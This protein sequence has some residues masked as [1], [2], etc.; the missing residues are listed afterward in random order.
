MNGAPVLADRVCYTCCTP[1]HPGRCPSVQVPDNIYG[2]CGEAEIIEDRE[3]LIMVDH[4][5][6]FGE[7][8]LDLVDVLP[9]EAG[10]LK[11]HDEH[12]Q[13]VHCVG[14]FPKSFL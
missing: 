5:K 9:C 7:V 13:L 10:V 8:N 3:H 2:I 6:S 12:L 1:F 11:G 4:F 14:E